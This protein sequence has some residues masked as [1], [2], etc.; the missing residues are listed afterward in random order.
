MSALQYFRYTAYALIAVGL[1]NLRYQ[2]GKS[3]LSTTTLL[4]VGAGIA[5]FA[6]TYLNFGK[7]VI[8]AMAAVAA[9]LLAILN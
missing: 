9:G 7:K 1:I 5:I 3:N 4:I 8:V 6:L 2:S